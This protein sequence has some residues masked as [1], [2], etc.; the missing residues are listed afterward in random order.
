MSITNTRPVKPVNLALRADAA[1]ARR[2]NGRP[3]QF[4]IGDLMA[5]VRAIGLDKLTLQSVADALEVTPAALYRHFSSKDDLV[6]RFVADITAKFPI[7]VVR[8]EDWPTWAMRFGP[9]LLKLYRAVPGLADYSIRQTQTSDAVLSRHETS[10]EA[11]AISGLGEVAALYAMRALV[12][13]VAGWAAR[14]QRRDQ[15]ERKQ[16]VHPDRALRDFVLGSQGSRYPRLASA[17]RAETLQPA[18][19]RFDFTLRALIKGCVAA[20][21]AWAAPSGCGLPGRADLTCRET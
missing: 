19:A 21:Q 20:G 1:P 10:M 15:L 2:S 18:D 5:A 3:P 14:E 4:S 13:F 8:G 12:E 17:L 11:A 7:P 6:D 9:A 16:G